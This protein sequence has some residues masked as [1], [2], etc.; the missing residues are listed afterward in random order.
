[1]GTFRMAETRRYRDGL[2]RQIGGLSQRVRRSP[3]SQ[4]FWDHYEFAV[5]QIVDFCEASGL[6]LEGQD[7]A[8]VGCGDGIM[9]LGLCH[10]VGPRQLVAFDIVPTDAETLLARSRTEGVGDTLPAEL[11]FRQSSWRTTPAPDASFDL[12]YS[13]SAFEHIADPIGV[14]REIRRIIRPS[15]VFF[16]QLWPFYNSAKGSHLWDWFADD[17]HHL[18]TGY[19]EI[20]EQMRGSDVH[21]TEWTDYMTREFEHLNRITL[22]ELQRAILVAGFDVRRLELLTSPTVL[23]PELA[24]YSWADVGIGGIKLLAAP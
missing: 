7:V 14:L 23:T 18:V 24:R 6:Q 17:F 5:G 22:E 15:G 10:R 11:E 13:W 1:M 21:S 16:L 8:D 4:W 19:R 2:R 3:E 12:V 20:V 9:A